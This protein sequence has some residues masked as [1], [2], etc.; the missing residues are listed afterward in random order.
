MRNSKAII[1]FTQNVRLSRGNPKVPYTAISWEDI[2]LL[3]SAMLG[4]LLE[5]L[6]QLPLVNVFL[7]TSK[8]E[9]QDDFLFAFHNRVN[10]LYT[11]EKNYN[12][13]VAFAIATVFNEGYNKVIAYFDNYP[14]F[15]DNFVNRVFSQLNYEDDCIVCSATDKGNCNLIAMKNNYSSWFDGVTDEQFINMDH[16]IKK[17]CENKLVIFNTHNLPTIVNGYDLQNLKN[18]IQAQMTFGIDYPKKTHQMFNYLDKKL[19]NRKPKDE[20]WD[21]RRYI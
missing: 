11:T 6:T 17:A 10:L 9:L 12:R 2:D 19:K 20:A 13:R 8:T 1:L 5:I 3:F 18:D 21:L 4:D 14:L 15:K 16:L 7:V